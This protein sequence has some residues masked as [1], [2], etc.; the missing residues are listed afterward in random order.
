MK[1]IETSGKQY[2]LYWSCGIVEGGTSKN[3]ETRV[4]GSGG[5]SNGYGNTA[6]VNISSTTTIHDQFFL[7]DKKGKESSFQ[8]QDFNV[9]CREGNEL[10]VIWAIKKGGKTGPYIVVHNRTTS[11]TFFQEA[12][13]KK[14]FR[15]PAYY[16]LGATILLLI[17][18]NMIGYGLAFMLII[19]AWV[20]WFYLGNKE[21]KKFK[22]EI[23]FNEFV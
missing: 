13:L 9:A 1:T 4:H 18:G 23:N 20:A 3:M 8:L 19:A 16:P 12:E 15:Y 22:S 2:E 11:G 10:S 21:V 5:G 6:P 7:K 17:L 14:I